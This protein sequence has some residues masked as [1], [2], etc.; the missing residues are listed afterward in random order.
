MRENRRVE[1]ISGILIMSLL[2]SSAEEPQA[3]S[4]VTKKTAPE[5]AVEKV[6]RKP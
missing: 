6:G 1:I 2:S 3:G 5:G 4:V